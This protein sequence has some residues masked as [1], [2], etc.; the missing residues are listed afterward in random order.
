MIGFFISL[1]VIVIIFVVLFPEYA[2]YI[3]LLALSFEGLVLSIIYLI[4]KNVE[5]IVVKHRNILREELIDDI[6]KLYKC[7]DLNDVID[8]RLDK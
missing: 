1:V 2:W 7:K 4:N 8:W 3:V 5:S 6:E